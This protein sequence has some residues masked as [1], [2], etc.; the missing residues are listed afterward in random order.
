MDIDDLQYWGQSR[1]Y[2]D[3]CAENIAF[4]EEV[5]A[6]HIRSAHNNMQ[7]EMEVT[8]VTFDNEVVF[9][10]YLLHARCWEIVIEEIREIMAD[11]PPHGATNPILICTICES[12]IDERDAFIETMFAEVHISPRSPS[13]MAT[14][15][16]TP[17]HS[18]EPVCLECMSHVIEEYF[19]TWED[20]L[21][22]LPINYL[23]DDYG[24]YPT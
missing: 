4:T 12:L 2:C 14:D 20:L 15:C 24:H 19:S 9:S 22:F 13:G 18:P 21:A 23:E 7:G 10:P 5:Y 6:L 1:R 3:K 17:M 16:L 8:E 11:I